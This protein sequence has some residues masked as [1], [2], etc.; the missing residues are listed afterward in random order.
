[1]VVA[2]SDLPTAKAKSGVNVRVSD[3]Q[4][5]P[6]LKEQPMAMVWLN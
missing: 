2:V 3:Y 5:Q 1:M 4:N 6:L